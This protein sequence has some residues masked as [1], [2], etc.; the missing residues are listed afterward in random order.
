MS[1]NIIIQ[2]NGVDQTLTGTELIQTNDMDNGTIHWIPEDELVLSE[3]NVTEPGTYIPGA[4]ICGFSVVTATLQAQ[5]ITG[6]IDG[7][8]YVVT[9]DSDGNLVYTPQS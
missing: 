6:T 4:G 2:K 3:L 9:V 7:V 5:S 1:K 8:T